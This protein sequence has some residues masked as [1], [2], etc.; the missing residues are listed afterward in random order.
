MC[1]WSGIHP[2]RTQKAISDGVDLML[3]KAIKLLGKQGDYNKAP[4]LMDGGDSSGGVDGE[5]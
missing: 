1:Y 5:I 3:R 2:E 4:A